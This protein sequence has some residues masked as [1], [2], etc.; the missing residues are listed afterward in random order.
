MNE[1]VASTTYLQRKTLHVTSSMDIFNMMRDVL[2]DTNVKTFDA[3]NFY[4]FVIYDFISLFRSIDT[5]SN[6]A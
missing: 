6:L 5:N 4:F 1:T 2:D 3:F